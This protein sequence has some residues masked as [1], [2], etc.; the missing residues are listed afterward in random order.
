[1]STASSILEDQVIHVKRGRLNGLG[2]EPAFNSYFD[3]YAST[4]YLDPPLLQLEDIAFHLFLRKNLNDS[5]PKWKMPT[6]RQIRKKF[7]MGQH[8]IEAMLKRLEAAHLLR[9]ESGV[10]KGEYGRNT[11]NDYILSDPLQTLEEFLIVAQE[12]VFGAPLKEEWLCTQNEYTVNPS[13]V[14]S[15]VLILSTDQQT[16]TAE[17]GVWKNV[18]EQLKLCMPAATFSMF[19]QDTELLSLAE[20]VA[21][22]ATPKP[23]TVDWLR[24]RLGPKIKRAIECELRLLDTPQAVTELRFEFV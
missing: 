18:L 17:Q 11:R 1:M 3:F 22:I 13:W 15:G 2:F 24:N 16:L 21:T 20:G 7:R 14:H 9:K 10:G 23:H 12:G 8:K 6:I 4:K 5:N 19:M